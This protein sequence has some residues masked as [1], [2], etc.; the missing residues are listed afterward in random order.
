M[1]LA[2]S[3]DTLFRALQTIQGVVE[4]RSS[5]MP[6]LQNVLVETEGNRNIR[7]LGTNL[8]I[9]MRGM[10][11]AEVEKAGQVTLNARNCLTL[12]ESFPRRR[13]ALQKKMDM[14]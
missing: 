13:F 6:I 3:R 4:N 5:A 11:E 8:D 7:L 10:F 1:E 9:S 2:I 14:D 12:F